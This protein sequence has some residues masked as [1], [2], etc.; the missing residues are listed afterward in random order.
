M[1]K[2]KKC[3]YLLIQKQSKAFTLFLTMNSSAAQ[4]NHL[5]F[6]AYYDSQKLPQEKWSGNSYKTNLALLRRE[7]NLTVYIPQQ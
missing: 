4:I 7:E 1:Q 2:L 6:F 5:I 3:M